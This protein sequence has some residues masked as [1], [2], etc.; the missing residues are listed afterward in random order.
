MTTRHCIP[1]LAA[2]A[3]S[4]AFACATPG[5]TPTWCSSFTDYDAVYTITFPGEGIGKVE[6]RY[7]RR[8][9]HV[10]ETGTALDGTLSG[11]VE[12]VLWDGTMYRRSSPPDYPAGYG[13]WRVSGR[14]LGA[15]PRLYCAEPRRVPRAPSVAH[16][17]HT[18]DRGD[19]PET[20]EWWYDSG[21]RPVRERRTLPLPDGGTYVVNA[22]Y[23]GHGEPNVIELPVP[24]PTPPPDPDALTVEEY[25]AYCGRV[26]SEMPDFG[27][28]MDVGDELADQ[29]RYLRVEAGRIS[30][31]AV[32]YEY[33]WLLT[34]L[35][36]LM[37]YAGLVVEAATDSEESD[38]REIEAALAQM[39]GTLS[40]VS[41]DLERVN[42]TLDPAVKRVLEEH[43]C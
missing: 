42:R 30:P 7:S 17:T 28:G 26:A 34:E 23:S 14:D 1:L 5:P 19:G 39:L 20:Y 15:P 40:E 24:T 10:Q 31:P 3:V 9:S 35:F 43:G 36:D 11:K 13:E 8:G 41:S 29:A 12:R 37:V 22:I 18:I 21:G 16:S 2:L 25:A 27:T 4:G 38:A 6:A 33:H 32:L